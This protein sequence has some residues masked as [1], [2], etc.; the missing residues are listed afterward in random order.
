MKEKKP[1]R[2]ICEALNF[3]LLMSVDGFEVSVKYAEEND[4]YYTLELQE[5]R[6]YSPIILKEVV[7]N[8]TTGEVEKVEAPQ[9]PVQEEKKEKGKGDVVKF[10]GGSHYRTSQ[11]SK[12][13]GKPRTVGLATITLTAPGNKHPYHLIGNKGG[14][15]VY[16]WVDEGSFE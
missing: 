15:D 10:L 4:R 12:P 5:W 13:T 14:S 6:D 11:A 2:V 3:N 1:V 16:G 8:K 9:H 7:E